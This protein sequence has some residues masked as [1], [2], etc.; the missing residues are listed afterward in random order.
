MSLKVI[1]L[2]ATFGTA[3]RYS[4]SSLL[5]L[6][7]EIQYASHMIKPCV[8]ID[9]YVEVWH[10]KQIR[11]EFLEFPNNEPYNISFSWTPTVLDLSNIQSNLYKSYYSFTSI[12]LLCDTCQPK[13]PCYWVTLKGVHT[14]RAA[15]MILWYFLFSMHTSKARPTVPHQVTC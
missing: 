10:H 15:F 12:Y 1:I 8:L 13:S 11:V 5:T 9:P 2:S 7:N 4:K 14:S 3:T 6:W